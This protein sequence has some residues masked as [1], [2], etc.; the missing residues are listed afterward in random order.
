MPNPGPCS[1][2]WLIPLARAETGGGAQHGIILICR[3]HA[4]GM[5]RGCWRPL[6]RVATGRRSD[7]CLSG[8]HRGYGTFEQREGP[9]TL[10][11]WRVA[12]FGIRRHALRPLAMTEEFEEIDFTGHVRLNQFTSKAIHRQLARFTDWLEQQS[13][14][15]VQAFRNRRSRD[16]SR[17]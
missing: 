4:V 12:S 2:A 8:V 14:E 13:G 5:R 10:T 9:E 3:L 1:G 16:G 11:R 15:T 17:R 7:G 6:L